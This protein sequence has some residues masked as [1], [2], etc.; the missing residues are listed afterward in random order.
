[1][2]AVTEDDDDDNIVKSS[3][4]SKFW[5]LGSNGRNI[6]SIHSDKWSSTAAELAASNFIA[7]MPNP[8]GGKSVNT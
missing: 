8:A 4:A 1:M 3:S 2:L 7:I 6:D 5:L